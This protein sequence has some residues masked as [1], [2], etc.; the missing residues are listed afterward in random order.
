[1]RKYSHPLSPL[2]CDI[3]HLLNVFS[4]KMSVL[5]LLLLLLLFQNKNNYVACLPP[6]PSSA[7]DPTV[8][9]IRRPVKNN[10][11][12][13]S[14]QS[15]TKQSAISS[16]P[17]I[18]SSNDGIKNLKK[19]IQ[20][21]E[22]S[23]Y[24]NYGSWGNFRSR[25]STKQQQ[26]QE[27]QQRIQEQDLLYT[28]DMSDDGNGGVSVSDYS[29]NTHSDTDEPPYWERQQSRARSLLN[30]NADGS[31]IGNSVGNTENYDASY[32]DSNLYS[33]DYYSSPGS[34]TS[35]A[36][37]NSNSASNNYW[38]K[39]YSK[40]KPYDSNKYIQ[41]NS[42]VKLIFFCVA[43]CVVSYLSVTPRSLPVVEYNLEYK[44][45]LLR[46]FAST[47]W[48]ILVIALIFRSDDVNIN[49]VV[50][51]FISSVFI[52]YPLLCMIELVIG[53]FIRLLILRITEI[54]VFK[55]CPKSPGIL[56]P[57]TFANYGYFPSRLTLMLFYVS[58]N[59]IMAPIV[60]EIFK[61]VLLRWALKSWHKRSSVV[62]KKDVNLH[63]SQRQQ[64]QLPLLR[65]N[66]NNKS[67][68][69][70]VTIRSYVI[71][72]ISAALGIKVADNI[73]RI[74]L[75]SQPNQR[76][77]MFFA[78]TRGIFPIQELCGAITALNLARHDI[79]GHKIS[80]LA[81]ISPSIVLHI[82]AN[83][84][85]VK[86]MFVWGSKRPWDEIQLQAWNAA[87]SSKPQQLL[88]SGVMNLLWFMLLARSLAHVIHQYIISMHHQYFKNINDKNIKK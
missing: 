77:K 43:A 57:W 66:Y 82:M 12:S 80:L 73:R 48:P 6:L 9:T 25:Y 38:T 18:S 11:N 87:D 44:S 35:T 40:L 59:I 19:L 76:H 60:E 39:N 62:N 52:G 27:Q 75:Y 26:Q 61:V 4:L 36:L 8:V 1:M 14:D 37:G 58:N 64:Q 46:V 81:S 3:S 16:N 49:L 29:A 20:E 63:D 42:V 56:L 78:V 21:L 47:L 50:Q 70:I 67:N 15:S 88:F 22:E 85:G 31:S 13:S 7:S 2:R 71:L 10:S 54:D 74:L 86:P 72:M 41:F 34:S 53:T 84:R 32:S 33:F 24:G 55:L 5:I 51:R 65:Q 79:L 83:L 28:N 45:A 30:S 17:S 68:N 23:D 69:N